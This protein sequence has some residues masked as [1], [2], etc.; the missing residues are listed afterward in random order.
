[1]L[2]R[3]GIRGPFY[4]A[5]W[6]LI[7]LWLLII[8]GGCGQKS[9]KL[10]QYH[11]NQPCSS[12]ECHKSFA[13]KPRAE[14]CLRCHSEIGQRQQAGKGLHALPEFRR[15]RSCAAKSDGCHYEHWSGE[16]LPAGWRAQVGKEGVHT[17]VSGFAL[18]GVHA[19]V[20]CARCHLAT[21]SARTAF[22]NAL[23]ACESCHA[24]DSPHG[25]VR[26]K[27]RDCQLCHS[28]EPVASLTWP[29]RKP[30]P[31]DHSTAT[32]FRLDGTIHEPVPCTSKCHGKPPLFAKAADSFADCTPCHQDPHRTRF[33]RQPNCSVCHTSKKTSNKWDESAFDHGE[34]TR[35]LLTGGHAAPQ[36]KDCRRCHRGKDPSDFEDLRGLV[37]SSN[38]AF[39]INCVGCHEHTK[40][41]GGDVKL[42]QCLICH[43]PG[44]KGQKEY[45]N[46]K[47]MA[48]VGHPP[49]SRFPLTGGHDLTRLK[50]ESY[51]KACHKNVGQGFEKLPIDCY[52]CHK[53]KDQQK[54]H[55]GKLGKQCEECHDS[56]TGTFKN[57]DRFKHKHFPLV[58]AHLRPTACRKCHKGEPLATAFKP[59]SVEAR[60]CGNKE[61]HKEKV[62]DSQHGDIYRDY[63]GGGC[64][65]P[66]HQ[67]FLNPK[68]WKGPTLD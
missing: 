38:A 29:L 2:L 6:S 5:A 17:Q 19:K 23:P 30:S 62:K 59:R 43:D 60:D 46:I 57:T 66:I 51:C 14:Q 41:H 27:H 39:P 61:C 20:D 11:K 50:G 67:R 42:R 55:R 13:D 49:K 52:S 28:T 47:K 8:F 21:A 63:C 34:R 16:L 31:F 25:A 24:K 64:H 54:G 33:N 56:D 32:N 35:F 36:H 12:G 45:L 4:P 53:E 37:T 40:A 3:P 10:S 48:Y 68:T 7:G 15:E 65:N 44:K 26:V 22:L 9:Y 58:G 18:E 1:M